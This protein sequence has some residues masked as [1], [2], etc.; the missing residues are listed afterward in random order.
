[1][2][3]VVTTEGVIYS[4]RRF[5]LFVYLMPVEYESLLQVTHHELKF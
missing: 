3:C 2:F 4:G 5:I 1:M